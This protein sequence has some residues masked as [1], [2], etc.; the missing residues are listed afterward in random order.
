M[1]II[2][3]IQA[4]MTSS[5]LPGKV[6]KPILGK[7][8]LAYLLERV[9]RCQ[10]MTQV[11]VATSNQP[12]DDVIEMFC[13]DNNVDCFRGDLHDVLDRYYQAAIK[14]QADHVVRVTADCPLIDPTVMDEIIECHLLG[15][16]DYTSNAIEPCYP[17]G[18]DVEVI[19]F[20]VLKQAWQK[21]TMN[22]ERE[23]VTQYI[24]QNDG[25]YKIKSFLCP[26]D[27][28][29][30][31]LTVDE[32]EDFMLIN[33]IFEELYPSTPTFSYK[34][35]LYFLEQNPDL[36]QLNSHYMRNEGFIESLKNDFTV[37]N[38]ENL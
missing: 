1:N 11:V 31:R 37:K 30:I 2:V 17:D 12:E 15:Q 4:R 28:S 23:H 6:L 21:A 10:T 27:L 38:M 22:S 3:I 18:L 7:P 29:H 34:D 26:D 5:R 8:M 25:I 32:P 24:L 14:Y 13:L 20:D 16:Y 9:S 36:I 35:V 33:K 19:K